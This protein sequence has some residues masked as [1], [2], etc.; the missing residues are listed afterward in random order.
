MYIKN[1]LINHRTQG[2]GVEAVHLHGIASGLEQL[3][4]QSK[5]VSPPGIEV[6]TKDVKKGATKLLARY[7]PQFIFEL[8]ELFSN[9]VSFRKLKRA[10]HEFGCDLLYD[11]YAFLGVSAFW[12]ARKWG[13]PL[14]VEVNYLYINDLSVRSRSFILTPL[15]KAFEKMLLKNADLLLPVSTKLKNDLISLG[16]DEE[17][18]L[19]SPNAVDLS[20]FPMAPQKSDKILSQYS[21]PAE[22]KVIGFVGSF[23]PWHRVDMLLDACN[24][25]IKTACHSITLLLIGDGPTRLDMELA[26]KKLPSNIKA[27][28]TGFISHDELAE[29]ISIIDIAVMPHSNDYG[30]PM[31]IF[32]YMALGKA[33]VAPD[34]GPLRD[35]IDDG[36]DGL[37]FPPGDS[38]AL[39]KKLSQL[40]SDDAFRNVIGS[41]A[42][43][44]VEKEHNWKSR[45]EAMLRLLEKQDSKIS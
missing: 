40:I 10:K 17:K 37:L 28:F 18:I 7:A 21:I 44:R 1:A 5:F 39:M 26:A 22:D 13:V 23:A 14:V 2:K 6:S 4:V 3:G 27:V 8:L 35:A 38:D 32:E 24:K 34:F 29:H 20:F 15:T 36:H 30:S 31:K 25:L 19:V 12:A 9:F 16:Y 42:R 33:V 45:C 41:K 43:L 11:R